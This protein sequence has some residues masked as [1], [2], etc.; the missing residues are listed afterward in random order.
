M[1]S[2]GIVALV[3]GDVEPCF[4]GK[5]MPNPGDPLLLKSESKFKQR[6]TPVSSEFAKQNPAASHHQ[7]PIEVACVCMCVV[8]RVD[9]ADGQK[10]CEQCAGRF[11]QQAVV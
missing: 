9:E 3:G 6:C 2:E 11:G 8:S 7:V 5:G 10:R 4:T 1:G